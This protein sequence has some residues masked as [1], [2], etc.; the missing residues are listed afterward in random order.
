MIVLVLE[1]KCSKNREWISLLCLWLDFLALDSTFPH[2]A[3]NHKAIDHRREHINCNLKSNKSQDGKHNAWHLSWK[4]KIVMPIRSTWISYWNRG[5]TSK[6]VELWYTPHMDWNFSAITDHMPHLAPSD[7]LHSNALQCECKFCLSSMVATLSARLS[8]VV[9]RFW[10]TIR[11]IISQ[12]LSSRFLRMCIIFQS[13][14]LRV[15]VDLT[16]VIALLS[17]TTSPEA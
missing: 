2:I 12:T 16:Y 8:T 1:Q 3:C 11:C 7:L 14:W 10:M 17:R 9:Q 5:S 4:V 13:S 15:F 6:A